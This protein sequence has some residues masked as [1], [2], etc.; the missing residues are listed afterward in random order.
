[1]GSLSYAV[2]GGLAGLGQGMAKV[3]EENMKSQLD[4][5]R[6]ATIERLR[7]QNATDLQSNQQDFTREQTD[8]AATRAATAAGA[9]RTFEEG[10]NAKKLTSEEKRA[11]GHDAAKLD[12]AAISSYSKTSSGNKAKPFQVHF[13]SV[14]PIDPK[15]GQPDMNGIPHNVRM[16]FDP[17]TNNSYAEGPDGNFYRADSQSGQIMDIRGGNVQ[18]NPHFGQPL[19]KASMNRQPASPA[20]LRAL[21]ATPYAIVPEGHANAGLTYAEAYEQEY[22]SLPKQFFGAAARLSQQQ[23]SSS[24][25]KLP[26]GRVFNPPPGGGGGGSVDE[27]DTDK[28]PDNE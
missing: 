18:A 22:G 23:S 13:Q 20:T 25:F 10:E 9:T 16:N 12:A 17:N 27:P 7:A 3:G 15:T 5:A 1:M 2:G 21:L 19:D 24:G 8:T 6:D 28:N 26:S 4:T 14:Y 11:S